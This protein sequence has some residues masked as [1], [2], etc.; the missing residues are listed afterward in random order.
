M[1]DAR[2]AATSRRTR[3]SRSLLMVGGLALTALTALTATI[4]LAAGEDPGT[5]LATSVPAAA[6]ADDEV[7]ASAEGQAAGETPLLP[8]VT[9]EVFL[10]RDPFDPVVPEDE[11]APDDGGTTAPGDPTATPGDPTTAPNLPGDPVATP[12]SPSP[13][14]GEPC[15]GTSEV[16]CDGRVVNLIDVSTTLDGVAIAVVQVDTTVY[17]VGVGERFAGVFEVRAIDGRCVTLLYGDDAFQLCRG[18]TV[19][20]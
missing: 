11:P 18:D 19:L 20:K 5:S 9:Y 3:P 2:H 15:R 17:E 13:T 14:P 10:S 7:D 4:V 6:S 8:I 12:G 16:V 1:R